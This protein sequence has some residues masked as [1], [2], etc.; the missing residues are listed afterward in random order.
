[1]SS[2]KFKLVCQVVNAKKPKKSRVTQD[3]FS[4]YIIGST[5]T[6]FVGPIDGLPGPRRDPHHA[7]T[8]LSWSGVIMGPAGP[9]LDGDARPRVAEEEDGDA[10]PHGEG[11]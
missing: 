3:N 4:I 7:T 5:V 1:M 10:V 2:S 9:P 8:K 6:H 11:E